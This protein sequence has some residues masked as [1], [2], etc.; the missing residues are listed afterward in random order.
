MEK[1]VS[2][3]PIYKEKLQIEENASMH[4]L[5]TV[6]KEIPHYF[7]APM[8]LK[9]AY[10]D[11]EFGDSFNLIRFPNKFF[12]SPQTYNS[13]LRNRCFFEK[14]K[15]Y[16]H[17]LMYHTDAWVF[18]NDLAYWANKKYAYIGAPLYEY[19]GTL[20][21]GKYI[22]TGQGGFSL[23]HI[24]SAIKVLNSK[25]DVYTKSD[26]N[27]WYKAYNWKGRLR[28]LGYYLVTYFGKNRKSFS[29]NNNIKINEDVWWGKYVAEAFDWYKVPTEK[30]ASMF[31]MEFNC[32]KLLV[33]NNHILP[34]G[35][36]QWYK[37]LFKDFWKPHIDFN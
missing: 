21:G 8:N 9:M 25:K 20:E 30:D 31:S 12:K 6:L 29:G 7:I 27:K 13:L 5:L 28:Y 14:F 1:V 10:Y 36:H 17:L 34:M 24:P 15:S 32:K 37:P 18:K 23:H 3:T 4:Q 22:C 19:N 2:I 11:A 33:E 26:L 35:T 16:T